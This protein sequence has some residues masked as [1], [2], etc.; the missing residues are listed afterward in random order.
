MNAKNDEKKSR[1][2]I[3]K[4][5]KEVNETPFIASKL[6]ENL[7]LKAQVIHTNFKNLPTAY[8]FKGK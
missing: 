6:T 5:T 2:F 7:L 4:H 8:L 1:T 3:Q